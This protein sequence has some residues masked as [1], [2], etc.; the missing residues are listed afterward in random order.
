MKPLVI[1]LLIVVGMNLY[2]QDRAGTAMQFDGIDDYVLIDD[3]PSLNP[4]TQITLEAW[5]YSDQMDRGSWQEFIMK[6]GNSAQEPRQY[7]IRPRRDD[8][9]LEF[10]LHDT[11]NNSEGESSDSILTNGV[12]HHVAGT[13]DG[14]EIK[15]Y[16]NGILHGSDSIR[17]MIQTSDQPL[18]FGRLGSISAEYFSGRLDEVRIWNIARSHSQLKSTMDDTLGSAYYATEDSG[19]VGYWRFDEAE[20]DTVRDLSVYGNHG[21]IEGAVFVPS[22]ALTDIQ[23]I[24]SGPV[25]KS[26]SLRQNYPNPFNPLTNI[27]FSLTKPVFVELRVFNSAGEEISVIVSRYMNAG[28]HRLSF[29]GKHLASG[30]Y[31]YQLTAGEYREVKKMILL[32]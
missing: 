6:G 28:T 11:N 31:F 5:V 32:K 13:Y 17:F 18:T 8:G 9:R 1:L 16:I 10:R 7:Y 3:H 27:N 25:K 30:V 20:G 2:G 14:E 21:R 15:I 19:L 26:F 23:Q 22:G 4:S 12:W 29:S 24:E